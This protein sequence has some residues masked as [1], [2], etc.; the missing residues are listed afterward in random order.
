MAVFWFA[1]GCVSVDAR[2]L[3]A[4]R[5]SSSLCHLPSTARSGLLAIVVVTDSKH[6]LPGM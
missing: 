5:L 4:S 3:L 1:A 2:A 6:D